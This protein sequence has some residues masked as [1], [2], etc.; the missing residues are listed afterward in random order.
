[1]DN[2]P[3]PYRECCLHSDPRRVYD[4]TGWDPDNK[5]YRLQNDDGRKVLVKC[6][7]FTPLSSCHE[8]LIE[9]KE[10][11]KLH[12]VSDLIEGVVTLSL[13]EEPQEGHPLARPCT[14]DGPRPDVPARVPRPNKSQAKATG[15]ACP[16]R[17]QV[18]RLLADCHTRE[19]IANRASGLLGEAP[20]E[21]IGKYLHLDN[22]RFRM[23]I[24]NRLVGVFKKAQA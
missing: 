6:S 21:L 2:F 15:E 24:G 1:M 17:E 18:R 5:L 11:G 4:L 10:D 8:D 12:P 13:R 20:H 7:E 19:E 3:K 23:T 9:A 22:G 16:H 14:V